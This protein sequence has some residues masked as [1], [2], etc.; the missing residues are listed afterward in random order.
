MPSVR[1]GQGFVAIVYSHLSRKR[2]DAGWQRVSVK[3]DSHRVSLQQALLPI[4]TQG[5]FRKKRQPVA[6]P[7]AHQREEQVAA[8]SQQDQRRPA[9]YLQLMPKVRLTVVHHRVAD[10]I[11]EDSA[12]NII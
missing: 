12:A 7:F 6:V 10:I 4:V 11:A 2:Q 8:W 3:L 5:A 9:R 1:Y